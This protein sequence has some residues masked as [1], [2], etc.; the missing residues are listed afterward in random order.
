MSLRHLVL[1]V[2]CFHSIG[3]ALAAG[4]VHQRRQTS[5]S[6]VSNQRII[7][8]IDT[9]IVYA[10]AWTT[11][12]D[13][14]VDGR[15]ASYYG[16]SASSSATH[17]D[18]F[19]LKFNGSS[20]TYYASSSPNQAKFT[21]HLDGRHVGTCTTGTTPT[22][23][24]NV[25]LWTTDSLSLDKEH[26]LEI[27]HDD[28]DGTLLVVDRLTVT[29]PAN[30]PPTTP[31]N[32]VDTSASSSSSS[33]PVSAFESSRSGP[34]KG[35]II[36][37]VFAAVI[38]V[39]LL[40]ILFV[41]FMRRY[42][43]QQTEQPPTSSSVTSI[44]GGAG[45][46]QAKARRQTSVSVVGNK[47]ENAGARP[48][49]HGVAGFLAKVRDN[50]SALVA[51]AGSKINVRRNTQPTDERG[52]YLEDRKEPVVPRLYHA[53][54]SGAL[55]SMTAYGMPGYKLQDPSTAPPAPTAP[56][57]IP[58]KG[59]PTRSPVSTSYTNSTLMNHQTSNSISQTFQIPPAVNP[60]GTPKPTYPPH[61]TIH[62]RSSSISSINKPLPAVPPPAVIAATTAATPAQAYASQF[63]KNS[64]LSSSSPV[65]DIGFTSPSTG[66]VV[67]AHP[68]SIAGGV[69]NDPVT[70]PY[71]SAHS[72]H[73][74]ASYGQEYTGAADSSSTIGLTFG[75][76][77]ASTGRNASGR[78]S[79]NDGASASIASHA[80]YEGG[81]GSIDS[82]THYQGFGQRP[83][84][85]AAEF[86][87][88]RTR[89][90]SSSHASLTN[91]SGA[92]RLGG[93]TQ[94]SDRHASESLVSDGDGVVGS[95]T[96]TRPRSISLSNSILGGAATSYEAALQQMRE[97]RQQKQPHTIY[98]SLSNS[99]SRSASNLQSH[100]ANNS[101]TSLSY[102][103]DATS[104]DGLAKSYVPTILARPESRASTKSSKRFSNQLFSR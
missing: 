89:S 63:R 7:D 50:G 77:N 67:Y 61:Q 72:N 37:A 100:S 99:H 43:R 44:F 34:S 13:R 24:S 83:R 82:Q 68:Y 35:A 38:G 92:P 66:N 52:T 23:A 14:L 40:L 80:E 97:Q 18:S 12:G 3:V 57:Q 62:S 71:A 70:H 5:S 42:R 74:Y 10:G 49:Y 65:R 55:E 85:G 21:V 98:P 8:N 58:V 31:P 15:N 30:S 59:S 26:T 93:S 94:G 86:G 95:G 75:V 81:R 39:A 32:N 25:A 87:F 90:A 1:A 73:P 45:W 33:I 4:M 22:F 46:R 51:D 9:D 20:V 19:T 88:G 54:K 91:W 103:P 28:T 76:G 2:L 56:F 6:A 17:G 84:P 79:A 48:K 53:Y 27:S 47:W 36:G 78:S 29:L 69:G 102:Y 41:F 104:A 60:F 11:R 96:G 16:G 64:S 101:V